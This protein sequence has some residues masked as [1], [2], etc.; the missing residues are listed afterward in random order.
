LW[1]VEVEAVVVETTIRRVVV[2]VLEN[3]IIRHHIL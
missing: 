2:V 1:Q 3:F